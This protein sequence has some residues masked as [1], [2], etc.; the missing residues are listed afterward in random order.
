MCKLHYGFW[1]KHDFLILIYKCEIEEIKR[2]GRK[3]GGK[4]TEKS[5]S[6]NKF[7]TDRQGGTSL[8]KCLE[9]QR[10]EQCLLRIQYVRIFF[11]SS[12]LPLQCSETTASSWEEFR[13]KGGADK[14]WGRVYRVVM[15]FRARSSSSLRALPF[16]FWAYTSSGGGRTITHRETRTH[17]KDEAYM[18]IEW[19]ERAEG[20]KT[21]TIR[22]WKH[23][24]TGDQLVHYT[25]VIATWMNHAC[26]QANISTFTH[27]HADFP[28]MITIRPRLDTYILHLKGFS[29]VN[30]YG[31][32]S[33]WS[34]IPVSITS[35]QQTLTLI[36]VPVMQI[37]CSGCF[38]SECKQQMLVNTLCLKW[39]I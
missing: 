22:N 30:C 33:C 36:C 8:H 16:S 17:T 32:R 31:I 26:A 39:L 27:T 7:I 18:E 24:P 19:G 25:Q 35:K 38:N 14:M 11:K 3:Q 4:E 5:K 20:R 34:A 1:Q 28:N 13:Q 29:V 12:P 23:K 6:F 15:S 37:K 9:N 2:G 21:V 10:T